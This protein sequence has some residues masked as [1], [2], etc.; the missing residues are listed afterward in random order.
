MS[1]ISCTQC[2][3]RLKGG[4]TQEIHSHY[5][6]TLGIQNPVPTK[7]AAYNKNQVNVYGLEWTSESLTFKVNGVTTLVH[8][9]LHLA[10]ESTKKQ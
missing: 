9:N 1:V 7:T 6:N 8:P 2:P 4:S 3:C 10:D 5:K